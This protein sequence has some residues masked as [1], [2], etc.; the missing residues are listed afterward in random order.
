MP[1]RKQY[2]RGFQGVLG[3]S[4]LVISLAA[5]GTQVPTTAP[6]A[7]IDIPGVRKPQ[8]NVSA[9]R[10]ALFPEPS[11]KR[12]TNAAP[13]ML[14]AEQLRR[15]AA[16]TYFTELDDLNTS[17]WRVGNIP[18]LRI[19]LDKQYDTDGYLDQLEATNATAA[20]NNAS[21]DFNLPATVN[22]ATSIKLMVA[23]P[24]T[25]TSSSFSV[26]LKR[27]DTG[28]TVGSQTV[29]LSSTNQIA[30]YSE[31]SIHQVQN[32]NFTTGGLA[33]NQAMQLWLT[34][35]ASGAKFFVGGIRITNGTTVTSIDEID[36]TKKN[37]AGQLI[38]RTNN[39]T[40]IKKL[41]TPQ[42]ETTAVGL[43]RLQPYLAAGGYVIQR[44]KGIGAGQT[45]TFN[46]TFAM[47][48]TTTDKTISAYLQDAT[49]FAQIPNSGQYITVSSVAKRTS[50]SLTKPASATGDVELVLGGIP[51]GQVLY[52][53]NFKEP[54][55]PPPAAGTGLTAEYFDN[56]DLTGS[57]VKT[58]DGS[59]NFNWGSSVPLVGL[60]PTTYSV[61]WTGQIVPEFN[62]EYTFYVTS[63]DGARLMVNGKVLV[64]N[65]TDHASTVN[66]D[67]IMLKAG[68]KYDIRL[69]YYRNATNPG[70]VKLEWS[71]LSRAKAV[72]PTTKLLSE[73]KNLL[74]ALAIIQQ[75]AKFAALGV[76]LNP[77]NSITALTTVQ[78]VV[79]KE[80]GNL[81]ITIAE[82]NPSSKTI[83]ILW[84]LV[85]N[86]N[87]VAVT[88]IL[89]GK[90]ISISNA[91]S[92]FDTQGQILT[93]KLDLLV[94]LVAPLFI[95]A[96]TL[97]ALEIP[98]VSGLSARAL[99]AGVKCLA[100]ENQRERALLLLRLYVGNKGFGLGLWAV[101][102][103]TKVVTIWDIGGQGVAKYLDG[104][105]PDGSDILKEAINDF[106]KCRALNCPPQISGENASP[107]T[108]TVPVGSTAT[109]NIG[110]LNKTTATATLDWSIS[111]DLQRV[112]EYS[113]LSAISFSQ[114][115]GVLKPG[116]P[117]SINITAKCIF[118]SSNTLSVIII[119]N[120]PVRP[121]VSLSVKIDCGT[122]TA[123]TVSSIYYDNY[124]NSYVVW[125]GSINGVWGPNIIGNTGYKN[126]QEAFVG[127]KAAATTTFGTNGRILTFDLTG[128]ASV[129]A[130]GAVWYATVSS[131]N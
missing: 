44:L 107:A 66:S 91:S 105:L 23:K 96:D 79:A 51:F 72:V 75:N 127:F 122:K 74:D 46:G 58:V 101:L 98:T 2:W 128:P 112:S 89:S 103:P 129:T 25:Q 9:D 100:C 76:T 92:L 117:V 15:M 12:E 120:D 38:W 24:L 99:L 67:K 8:P 108:Q 80:V 90:A 1:N 113:G 29:T 109:V 41:F 26:A 32:L 48:T 94:Q 53:G 88:N 69:E 40:E 125:G 81:N 106:L 64:N 77:A 62:E 34:D 104:A 110:F 93:T 5:C 97:T 47:P 35:L 7:T 55:T 68:V 63:S 84:R 37:T 45:V 59:V 31:V 56:M 22:A 65:W 42:G 57:S 82:I 123:I 39:L 20:L 102:T 54:T 95:D 17:S 14:S 19:S 86:G 73:Q 126:A 49:T 60:Q 87:T 124:F 85:N 119:S 131:L 6:Q 11:E 78:T 116:E 50:F 27:A 13:G 61:R 28:A 33:A 36:F 118:V 115:S 10:P 30:S 16:G 4:A 71:S 83:N 70:A 21:T 52:A 130:P 43:H 3:L 121:V 114:T 111:L 18:F